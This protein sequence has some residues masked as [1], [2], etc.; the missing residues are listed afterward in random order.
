MNRPPVRLDLVDRPAHQP[1]DATAVDRQRLLRALD[2]A[3]A[4]RLTLISA[5]AGSGKSTLMNQWV[6]TGAMP[7][8]VL[9]P[10]VDARM[11]D[12]AHHVR[13]DE[14]FAVILDEADAVRHP[15]VTSTVQEILTRL[16]AMARV[17]AARR[18]PWPVGL[19]DELDAAARVD[20]HDLAFSREE[21]DELVGSALTPHQVDALEAR[22]QGWAAGALLATI[23]LRSTGNAA[24]FIDDF[25]G[26]DRHVARYLDEEVLQG[27]DAEDHVFLS[28]TSILD[29]PDP[30]GRT[31]ASDLETFALCYLGVAHWQAGSLDAARE[32]L[33]A[34]LARSGDFDLWWLRSVGDLALLE[35]WAGQLCLADDLATRAFNLAH[36]N[37]L[38]AHQ[39][40]IEAHLARAHVA[41]ERYELGD[42]EQHL[43]RARELAR[44]HHEMTAQV[45]CTI[46]EALLALAQGQ[47]HLGLRV[48]ERDRHLIDSAP[49]NRFT[50]M[51]DTVESSLR[52]ATGD[53]GCAVELLRGRD[54]LD[55]AAT[56]VALRA[57]LAGRDRV[58]ARE[59]VDDWPEPTE[60]GEALE[61]D[62]WL[63]VL[64]LLDG[65]R[66]TSVA[67]MRDLVP[68]LELQG[69]V[70]MVAESLP[71]SGPL[72]REAL[73]VEPNEHV[74][75]L[76]ATA[77]SL[78]AG[79]GEGPI[80]P[81]SEREIGI[82]RY[83]PTRLTTVEIAA[84]LFISRNTL[85]THLRSIYRK[86]EVSGRD[87]AVRRAEE[88]GLA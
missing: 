35:A 1:G 52:V 17:V 73:R 72:L 36:A 87:E 32:N 16:P 24:S 56:V 38:G 68:H 27:L 75:R 22:I 42:V 8:I 50:E 14:P 58:L 47:P 2:D 60:P 9:A 19:D 40:L 31:P 86:L 82:V 80:E 6:A 11:V 53:R 88:L 55:G 81:L 39:C 43:S 46:E 26:D 45:L 49:T 12:L 59:L 62:L 70:R 85:K 57:A 74:E 23:S 67:R 25:G 13:V 3:V 29:A 10:G 44:S 51:F 28:A 64:D 61:R 7:S 30:F 37:E 71:F 63:S 65:D 66:R 76:L 18:S 54:V 84:Q 34:A 15:L 20:E 78:P 69:H 48:V 5:P 21:F 4:G 41:R 83:L 77:A 79:D 33:H